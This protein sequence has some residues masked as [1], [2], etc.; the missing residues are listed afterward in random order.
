MLAIMR[1]FDPASITSRSMVSVRRQIRPSASRTPSARSR[2]SSG[3][4]SM[5]TSTSQASLSLYITGEGS[6][7]VTKTF[8]FISKL[9]SSLKH[10][11]QTHRYGLCGINRFEKR[12][13][14]EQ[15]FERKFR[16]IIARTTRA[17]ELFCPGDFRLQEITRYR[18]QRRC[19]V[20]PQRG[21]I[22]IALDAAI[23]LAGLQGYGQVLVFSIRRALGREDPHEDLAR[24]AI[25][26]AAQI[27]GHLSSSSA[28]GVTDT[29]VLN[30]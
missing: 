15:L 24:R 28:D 12:D 29:A 13:Q 25:A 7:R 2:R 9:Q 1:S 27:R 4:W 16:S 30:L 21:P 22:F 11:L 17:R 23:L 8:G 19:I 5:P 20:E 18:R 26:E 14:V 6:F 10:I 3:P